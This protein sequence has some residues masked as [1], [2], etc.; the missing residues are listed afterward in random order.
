MAADV[1]VTP[2]AYSDIQNNAGSPGE[3][4]Q[5]WTST[6]VGYFFFI[7]VLATVRSAFYTKTTDGGQTWGTPVKINDDAGELTF[8]G[9]GVWYDKDT[10]TQTGTKI[11]IAWAHSP[12]F[13]DSS[14]VYKFLDTTN[15][16]LSTQVT[17]NTPPGLGGAG[18]VYPCRAKD[19]T[20][21]I[22]TVGRFA[23]SIDEG[24]N[25]TLRTLH[26]QTTPEN[27]SSFM[28]GFFTDP[29]DMMIVAAD[30][31][32]GGSYVMRHYDDSANAWVTTT[33]QAH[34]G[35]DTNRIDSALRPSGG[36]IFVFYTVPNGT[37]SDIRC[38]EI[39]GETTFTQRTNLQTYTSQGQ[40][41]LGAL[42][43]ENGDLYGIYQGIGGVANVY[44]RKSSDLGV[45]WGAELLFNKDGVNTLSADVAVRAGASGGRVYAIWVVGSKAFG[46]YGT[47]IAL[48]GPDG[49]VS[50]NSPKLA[51]IGVAYDVVVLK[52][53]GTPVFTYEVI[54]PRDPSHYTGIERSAEQVLA[55]LFT[56][57]AKGT[58]L[59]LNYREGQTQIDTLVK[60]E[61]IEVVQVPTSRS[62]SGPAA[63]VGD[64]LLRLRERI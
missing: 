47:S 50:T 12:L 36:N 37:T 25:W 44:G 5:V 40:P 64:I 13:V 45:T 57:N 41:F 51:A 53:D 49:G 24:V 7:A 4:R 48:G 23:K 20:L 21:Y 46:N 43:A 17:V 55:D 35:T 22:L 30:S 42:F 39:T 61:R 3:K 8:R 28:P 14:L 1:Q 60:I 11:M 58:L 62:D 16:S 18:A 56:S 15:D 27:V 9:L 34:G 32:T 59:A 2:D 52:D 33:I 54:I 29:K 10:P 63:E 38:V 19:G 31:F 6:T 26:L